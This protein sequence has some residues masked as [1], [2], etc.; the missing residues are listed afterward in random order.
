[1]K[2]PTLWILAILVDQDLGNSPTCPATLMEVTKDFLNINLLLILSTTN[3]L[4]GAVFKWG[5]RCGKK[6]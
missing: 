5:G 2:Q 4:S 3:R 1:M 6:G